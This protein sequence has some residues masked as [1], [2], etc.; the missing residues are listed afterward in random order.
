MIVEIYRDSSDGTD[1]LVGQLPLE[2]ALKIYA[3]GESVAS[4]KQY[5]QDYGGVRFSKSGV[6]LL[7][8]D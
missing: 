5:I 6:M 1:K 4:M 2:E 8:A 7:P 3:P